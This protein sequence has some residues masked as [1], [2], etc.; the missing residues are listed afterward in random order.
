[1]IDSFSDLE[2]TVGKFIEQHRRLSEAYQALFQAYQTLEE[3]N[4]L[5]ESQKFKASEQVQNMIA[6]LKL[7]T[8]EVI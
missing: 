6:Q 4:K 3:K 7:M 5:L 1:M 8:E 2:Q